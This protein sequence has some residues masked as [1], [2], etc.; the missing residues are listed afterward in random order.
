MDLRQYFRKLEELEAAMAEAYQVV[1]SLQTSDGGK[2]G[3]V[4]EVSRANAAKMIVEGRAVLA[5]EEQ[6]A[7]FIAQQQAARESAQQV[8]MARRLQV[9]ILSEAEL[10]RLPGRKHNSHQK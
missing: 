5:T 10:G 6:K 8:E 4:S 9:A 7:E 1:V 2:A 3:L